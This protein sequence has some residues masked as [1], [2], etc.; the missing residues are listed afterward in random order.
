VIKNVFDWLES[1]FDVGKIHDPPR[2]LTD[3]TLDRD[4]NSKG[5][6]VEASTFMAGGTFGNLCA[7]S[8]VNSL[9]SS[10]RIQR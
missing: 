7:A 8:M 10:V 5:M 3:G 6:A 4:A 9:K 1:R 2:R